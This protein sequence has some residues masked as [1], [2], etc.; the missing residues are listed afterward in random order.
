MKVVN[1]TPHK[2]IV[3]SKNSTKKESYEPSGSIIRLNFESN[4]IGE[5]DGFP[6]LEN[7]L[8]GHNL[9]EKKEGVVYLVS[10][11]VLAET[12]KIGRD[13]FIAPNTNDSERNEKGHILSVH[14]FVS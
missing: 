7:K 3:E 9:P 6:I 8:V 13:D 14:S 5:L 10:A 1:M 12:K 2:I 4:Q 11:M